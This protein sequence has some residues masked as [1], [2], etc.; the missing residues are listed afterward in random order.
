MSKIPYFEAAVQ[1]LKHY[2][3]EIYRK[4]YGSCHRIGNDREHE[5]VI[6]MI[7]SWCHFTG[8]RSEKYDGKTGL[9]VHLSTSA[10]SKISIRI[11]G[12][13]VHLMSFRLQVQ[14]TPDVK[15]KVPRPC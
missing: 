1:H 7:C 12:F 2:T 15:K 5:C 8:Q 9:E 14:V 13:L 10:P 11:L 6:N 4:K 3:I